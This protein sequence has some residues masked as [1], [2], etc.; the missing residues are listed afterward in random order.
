VKL[1]EKITIRG[2]ELKNRMAFPPI[3]TAFGTVDGCFTNNEIDYMIERARGGAALI[4]TD[5]VTVDRAHQLSVKAKLPYLDNDEQISGYARYTDALRNEGVKTCIQLYHAGRQTT[6]AKRGGKDPIAPSAASTSLLGLIP[7]PDAVEMSGADIEKAIRSFVMAA[8]RAKTAGF[9]VVD[10]DGG[11]GY[12]IQQ[13]MS[14]Y[15]NKRDD[16]WGGTF[17]KRMRFPLEIV[18]RVRDVVGTDYPLV[19]DL[20]MDEYLPG[21]ITPEDGV[22]MAM[23]LEDAGIDAFRLHGVVLETYNRMF[24][25]MATPRGVNAPL[26]AMLKARLKARIM[27]GQRINDPGLAEKLLKDGVCDI[28]LLGRAL[29]ADPAFPGKV[30]AGRAKEIRRCIA[31]NTCVDQLALNKPI[32]CALNAQVGFEKEY[33]IHKAEEPKTILVAGGGPSGMEAARVAALAGHRVILCEKTGNLGGQILYGSVPPHKDELRSLLEYLRTQMDILGV[34]VRLRTRVNKTLI[35]K[36]KPDA[37][38]V[39]TGAV[40]ASPPIPGI[41]GN[42]VLFAQEVLAEPG[43]IKE[44]KV[45]IVGGGT[46]GAETAE[47]LWSRGKEVVVLEMLDTIA[48]DMGFFVSLDFRARIKETDISFIT[49]A[50]VKEIKKDGVFFDGSS[51]AEQFLNAD[52]VVLAVGY[53]PERALAGI[54]EGMDVPSIVVG[55]AVRPRNIM[56]AVHEGFHAARRLNES[57]RKG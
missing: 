50:R 30:A 9:D 49:G 53:T 36:M 43:I 46:V 25:T 31:C 24:P 57:L 23:T 44:K 34:E 21:G 13:F 45:L 26:G 33:R 40:P 27:L 20:P 48:P 5:G 17:D 28:I 41:D 1:F 42:Q 55:D 54:L 4:F 14:P 32:R 3:T 19:F 29:L 35:R 56:H 22:R 16:E 8:S 51:G 52:R 2:M 6:L 37:V 18:S 39:A 12:L 7:F 15:T 47:L 38:I 11:A 10:I